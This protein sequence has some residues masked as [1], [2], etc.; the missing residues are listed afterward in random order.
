[1]SPHLADHSAYPFN[2]SIPPPQRSLQPDHFVHLKA[3]SL[4]LGSRSIAN[5]DCKYPIIHSTHLKNNNGA[6]CSR[7]YQQCHSG[8]SPH[9]ASAKLPSSPLSSFSIRKQRDV[10]GL[11]QPSINAP[12]RSSFPSKQ[13]A[14]AIIARERYEESR[15]LLLIL[16]SVWDSAQL[17]STVLSKQIFS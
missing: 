12:L 14:E 9:C 11:V 8:N 1:M 13:A 15:T 16:L 10:D 2:H 3:S 6:F 7:H 5:L 17:Y 4:L